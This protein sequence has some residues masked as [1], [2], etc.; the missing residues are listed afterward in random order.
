[1]VAFWITGPTRSGKTTHL[2]EQLLGFASSLEPSQAGSSAC[3]WL[4]FAANGDNRMALANRLADQVQDRAAYVTST[5]AGFIQNEVILFWPLLVEQL[6]LKAQFPLK[7]RPENEQLLASTLWQPRLETGEILIE[8]WRDSQTVRRMLDFWQL[9]SSAMMPI[10]AIGQRLCATMPANLTTQDVWLAIGDALIEWKAWCLNRGILSYGLSNE[11]YWQH[12]LPHPHYQSQLLER[13]SGILADDLDEYPAI[14]ASPLALFLQ[15]K[16]PCC[17]TYND[18]GKVRL[19]LG[20]D[21]AFLQTLA[22]Q[23]E[24]IE[25]PYGKE[26]SLAYAWADPLVEWVKDPL[27]APELPTEFSLVSEITRG[28]LLRD[29]ANLIVEAIHQGRVK[30]FEVA[31]IGPGLDAIARYSLIEILTSKAIA[32]ESLNDQ[33]PLISSPLVRA[34]LSLMALVYPGLGRLVDRDAIAEMLVVLSQAPDMDSGL[35]WFE[36][37][38]IDPVRSELIADHC[39]VPDIEHPRLLAIEN[40]PRWDRLGYQAAGAYQEILQ[41]LEKQKQQLKQRAVR[42]PVIILD[43]AIQDFLWRGNYLPYDQLSALRELMETAEYFWEVEARLKLYETMNQ[44]RDLAMNVSQLSDVGRF[45]Q[46]LQ[47]GTVSANPY[48]SHPNEPS[49]RGVTL[50]TV[51]QYRSQRLSHRWQFWLDASSPRWLT[52]KDELFGAPAFLQQ[53]PER[54][55]RTEDIEAMHEERLERIIRDLL[56]RTTERVFLCHS[57]LALNGQEQMGPLLSL[58]NSAENY[59]EQTESHDTY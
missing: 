50:A 17:F 10:E 8:G 37:T 38:R 46:L 43:R 26:E 1:M 12:L 41:W 23:C 29:V 40:F 33:R 31:I 51:F 49:R 28:K 22:A 35:P 2:I 30:P 20:A 56:G 59:G 4:V 16:R 18:Y 9:A 13:F 15:Q 42:S 5:P 53:W 47:K 34:L 58:I 25:I 21:P 11:L 27:A 32:I 48:P 14:L 45:I 44:S 52:G 54:A 3:P 19:G 55:I 7:L 6:Q 57:D 24:I 36:L 39:F